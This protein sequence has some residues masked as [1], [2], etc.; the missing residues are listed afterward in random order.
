M[1]RLDTI[2][3]RAPRRRRGRSAS[4]ADGTAPARHK[5]PDKGPDEGTAG[6]TR[7]DPSVDRANEGEFG[8]AYRIPTEPSHA[9][10]SLFTE[11]HLQRRMRRNLRP[12]G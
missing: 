10:Q 6:A 5:G 12:S 8:T 9:S 11:Y 1:A 3:G 2:L 7:P 4:S